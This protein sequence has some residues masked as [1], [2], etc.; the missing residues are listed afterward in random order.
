MNINIIPFVIWVIAGLSV[1][2]LP[3]PVTKFEYALAWIC[4]LI[5]IGMRIFGI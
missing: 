1:L 3:K 5:Y 4:V 2:C